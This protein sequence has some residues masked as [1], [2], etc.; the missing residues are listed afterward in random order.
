MKSKNKSLQQK[1]KR[2]NK[3][4]LSLKSIVQVLEKKKFISLDCLRDLELKAESAE[5]IHR[6]YVTRKGKPGNRKYPPA[7][8][9]FALSLHFYS[10][11]AYMHVRRSFASALPHP[12]TL[13]KWYENVNTEPGFTAQAF[14]SLEMKF[15]AS[16]TR[17]TCTL[18]ADEMAIRQQTQWNG[19]R[20]IGLVDYGLG[21]TDTDEIATQVY[22]FVLVSND[23]NWKLPLG[24]FFVNGLT[25]STRATL[26]SM[27]L[28]KCHDVGVDVIALTFDGC[29]SNFMAARI[30]GCELDN[31]D[32]LV[33]TFKHPC[34]ENKVALFLD[35]CHMIKL[36]RNTFE[37]KRVIFDSDDNEI[38]WQLLIDLVKLQDSEGLH[39]A[40][41]LTSRHIEF[42]NQIMKVKLAVQLL[43]TSV[44]KA[45]DMCR[46][47]SLT[48]FQNV[49][50]TIKFIT[51][52][53]NLFDIFNSRKRGKYGF[54]KPICE[55]NHDTVL[56]YLDEM[57]MY[58]KSLKIYYK[59]KC[60]NKKVV[61][62]KISKKMI[63][64]CQCKT[65]F[66]GFL[67]NIQSLK[68]LYR[69]LI[70]SKKM[71]YIATYKIS[72][73]HIELLFGLIR[74]HGG[75]NN[76]P[77]A[78]QFRGIYRKLFNHLTLRSPFTG[79]CVPLDN[80]QI[81]NCSA[82]KAINHSINNDEMNLLNEINLTSDDHSDLQNNSYL[83]A[84]SLD[85]QSN[86]DLTEMTRYIV[87]YIAGFVAR[88]LNKALKCEECVSVLMS[89]EILQIHKLIDLKNKGG[90]V[91]P[92]KD[93]FTICLKTEQH[94]RNYVKQ[95][96]TQHF[97]K[98]NDSKRLI[99]TILKSF[100]STEIFDGLISHSFNQHATLN[101]R[102]LLI[103]AAI[104]TYM[105]VR[106]HHLHKNDPA[107]KFHT[108]RQKFNKLVLFEGK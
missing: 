63:T 27:C 87:A 106:L 81:L 61:S 8:R 29:S 82:V 76:N 4:I 71:S 58:I 22:V 32:N 59:T 80:Y 41:K 26:I 18:V 7:L 49:E 75:N 10:P 6:I 16:C 57:E 107:V 99:I 48:K 21:Q 60:I 88:K 3:K 31:V 50:S 91:L 23:Q 28:Q 70:E 103:K 54:K 66:T 69:T 85:S 11:S 25:G 1:N 19:K 12:R 38:K 20:T 24:Y 47:L 46:D 108:K 55:N 33:T 77:N 93:L 17:L 104:E 14:Q 40:N 96:G 83:L 100:Q 2:L 34:T 44:A 51:H 94:T 68:Y 79:N 9:K 43:S 39:V 98:E 35:P 13:R 67:V 15:K 30:L 102:T 95:K 97:L 65:G 89:K 74:S 5:M 45:L 52:F 37:A 92:S 56:K 36:V 90:L 78:T 84:K 53:N 101:H 42:R 105:N 73:D 62:M 86:S 72:Q 64:K